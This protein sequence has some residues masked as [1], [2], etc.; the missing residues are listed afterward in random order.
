[1]LRLRHPLSLL[2]IAFLVLLGV[3]RTYSTPDP[4]DADAPDVVFS[5][6]RAEAILRDLLRENLPHVSGSPY[7]TVVRNR[8]VAHLEASGYAPEIQS[9]FH[10]NPLYGSCSPVANVI[11]VKP[12]KTGKHAVLLTAH[13]DSAWAGPGAADDGAG[14]AAILEIARMAADFPPFDNDVL[15]LFSDS[16]ENGLIGA[17]A[18]AEQHP[19]FA[20][21]KAVINLEA[22]GVSGPSAMFETGDGNRSVIRMLSKNV[23][24]PVANSLVYEIYK[25]MPND[26]DYTVYRRKGVMGVNFAFAEGVAAYHSALDDPDHLDAGSLQHHGDNAWGMLKAFGERDLGTVTH[27]EDA[28]YMDLFGT[29]LAHYPVSI[30]GGLALVL[31]VWVMLA[32]GLAFRKEFRY[33]QLRWGLLAIPLMLAALFLG[34]Y[35][36]SWPLGRWPDLHPLEHPSPWVGR[37]T[38]FLMVLLVIYVTLKVFSGKVSACAWLVLSWALVF[39]L[40]MVLSSKLPTVTHIALLPLALFGLGSLIDLF[41]K[42]SPAPLLMASVLGFAAAAFVSFYHF[43]ML[44]VVMNFDRSHFKVIPLGLATLVA[45]PMLLAYVKDRDLSWLP[46]RWLAAA[47]LAGCLLH[48]FLP[49]Y[50]AER[51]RD[52]A[53]MYSEVDGEGRAHVVLESVYRRPDLDYARSHDF[54]ETELNDGRL[55]TV[56]RPARAVAALDLPGAAMTVG[57]ARPADE[58][59]EGGWRRSLRLE[60]PPGTPLLQLTFPSDVGLRQ[61]WVDGVLAHDASIERKQARQQPYLRLAYPGQGPIE[62]ELLTATADAFTFSAV[63]WHNLPSVLTAPFM[64]T[65]PDEARPAFNGPR[66]EKIQHFELPAVKK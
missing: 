18:F 17:H 55:G 1:M 25:R 11:A 7:N 63:T 5:A 14:V 66:A 65:W 24:R 23:D 35:V 58:E 57:E 30:A 52:M 41:R 56:R 37:L 21:V 61:A 49:G 29:R 33:R 15:F 47:L 51:P 19:S 43:F 3:L 54:A 16:E 64:G 27:P 13:Y 50:S 31:G 59:K 42:K 34:A 32:I 46:A 10:C 26:T 2:L 22:R 6:D 12:G 8:I 53:L 45:M 62:I 38:L 40:G 9:L 28:G 39:L 36:L 4:V 48:L 44:D 60:L 20:Q